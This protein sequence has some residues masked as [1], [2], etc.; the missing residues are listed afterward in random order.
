MERPE[1]PVVTGGDRGKLVL[2][3]G[4]MEGVGD[5]VW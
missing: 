5:L 1:G 3:F 4:D 2:R